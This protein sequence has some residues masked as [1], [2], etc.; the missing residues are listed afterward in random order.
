MFAVP[1]GTGCARPARTIAI[2]SSKSTAGLRS[3]SSTVAA[4]RSR[5]ATSVRSL[6]APPGCWRAGWRRPPGC[7]R[8]TPA[9]DRAADLL[10]VSDQLVD[11]FVDAP[12]WIFAEHR[13]L[14][15][16]VQ[17]QMDPEIGRAHV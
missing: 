14:G 6:R 16:I 12:E 1:S 5:T 9:T 11:P 10:H 3:S 4:S 15:L 8:G 13:S 2:T 17:L 7:G